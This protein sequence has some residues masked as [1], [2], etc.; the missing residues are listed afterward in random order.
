M[1][2][3][4][5]MNKKISAKLILAFA[6]VLA[7]TAILGVFSVRELGLV[8][9]TAQELGG[10]E[11]KGV[12]EIN[13]ITA[14]VSNYHIAEM[15]LLISVA[16]PERRAQAQRG[17]QEEMENLKNHESLYAPLIDDPEEKRIYDGFLANVA[18][19][20]STSQKYQDLIRANKVAE[21]SQLLEG[22]LSKQFLESDKAIDD[23]AAFQQKMSDA[24]VE[25]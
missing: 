22:E 2:M 21:A 5:F 13:Q 14:A 19:Y 1:K 6:F 15:N 20:F 4:W 11:M 18:Q 3:K 23:D 7:F 12:N 24:A 17:M 25:N 16:D 9:A 8:R 10:N